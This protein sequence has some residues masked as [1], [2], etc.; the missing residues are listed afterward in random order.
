[1]K[2]KLLI[3]TAALSVAAFLG[4]ANA[5][6]LSDSTQAP[7]FPAQIQL[8]QGTTGGGGGGLS[9]GQGSGMSQGGSQSGET[10]EPRKGSEKSTQKGEMEKGAADKG[11]MEKKGA[12]KSEKGEKS[13]RRGAKSDMKDEKG[14]DKKST[15]QK[16]DKDREKSARDND[17][18]DRKASDKNGRDKDSDRASNSKGDAKNV[19][20]DSKQETRI[21]TVIK[22]KNVTH[23]KRAD[24]HFSINVGTRVPASVHWYSLPVEIVE[25]VPQ[26]RGYYYIIV[27]E[28]IIIIA[29]NT[30][31]IVTVIRLA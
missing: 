24:I 18:G 16:G 9:G 29:P 15:E 7:H 17:K 20:L 26:Y 12:E 25:I 30:R 3:S 21:K 1:M 13:E 31:E 6:S 28:E 27:D 14:S 11:G 4:P 5:G 22:E 23:L 2:S 19:R 8:A 10:S